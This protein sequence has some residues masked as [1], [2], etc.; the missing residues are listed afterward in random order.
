VQPD[1][2]WAEGKPPIRGPT[3]FPISLLVPLNLARV[4]LPKSGVQAGRYRV[5][6]ALLREGALRGTQIDPDDILALDVREVL[7]SP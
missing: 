2:R 3:F 6:A 7:L 4:T 5:F 1:A